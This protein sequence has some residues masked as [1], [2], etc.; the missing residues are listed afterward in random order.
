MKHSNLVV[1]AALMVQLTTLSLMAQQN[2]GSPQGKPLIAATDDS[3]SSIPLDPEVKTGKLENGFTYYIRKNTE[4]KGRVTLYLVNKTGSILETDAQQGLAHF[5]EHMCFNGTKH[6]PKNELINYLQKSG[7]RFG[8][9]LNAYTGFNE[10]VYQLPVATD[11]PVVLKNAFQILRDWAQD[12]TLDNAEIDKERGVVME[13][14]RQHLGGQQRTENKTIPVLFNHSRYADRLPIGKEDI[15]RHAPY[16]VFKKFYKDWYRPD[17]Q[18]LIVVGDINVKTIEKVIIDKFSDL[19]TPKN[20]PVREQYTIPLTGNTQFISIT[21]PEVPVTSITMHIKQ[22][23]PIIQSAASYKEVVLRLLLND[24]LSTR[25]FEQSQEEHLPFTELTGQLSPLEGNIEALSFT[26]IPKPGDVENAFKGIIVEMER[27]ARFGFTATEI[28]MAK[29]NVLNR[30]E[31]ALK[32]KDNTASAQFADEYVQHFTKGL[33][34]P[35]IEYDYKIT[36][37]MLAELSPSVVHAFLRSWQENRNKDIIITANQKD[38]AIIPSETQVSRWMQEAIAG[39]ITAYTDK[40]S[41]NSLMPLKPVPGKLKEQLTLKSIDV[42]EIILS[43]GARVLLKPTNFRKNEI[44]ITATSPGGLSVIDDAD[45]YAAT[46]IPDVI[47]SGGVGNFNTSSLQKILANKEVDIRPTISPLYEG[48]TGRASSSQ[49]ETALQLIN[50]YF[51]KPRRDQVAFNNLMSKITLELNS[52]SSIPEAVFQDTIDA[53]SMDYHVRSIRPTIAQLKAIKLDKV[54]DLYKERFADAGNFTF[55]L[56]GNFDEQVILPLLETY[57]GSLPSTNSHETWQDLKL[58]PAKGHISRKVFQGKEPKAQVYLSFSGEME[59]ATWKEESVHMIVLGQILQMKLIERLR[60]EESGIYNVRVAATPLRSPSPSFSIAITFSCD[61]KNVEL[62][63]LATH[64][65]MDKLK[66]E[67]PTEEDLEKV[68]AQAKMGIDQS[69]RT[70]LFWL[71]S[72]VKRTEDAVDL[73]TIPLLKNK[74]LNTGL[75][76][77]KKAA[78]K[79]IGGENYMRFVLLPVQ[80]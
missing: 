58:H 57:L 52:R 70:N 80:E 19:K 36:K 49:L 47:M 16:E 59:T 4:P 62:L 71:N 74:V 33:P 14:L 60:E 10:T 43:N 68:H 34:C 66:Q 72:L 40:T 15:I 56:V 54:L 48:L 61:P 3:R 26:A 67:G 69:L 20:A 51:T 64:S 78:N 76:D 46:L 28:E 11:D 38:E 1:S 45:Y 32:E 39:N 21:D 55:V 29:T 8:A 6:Y 73:E 17:L 18:A 53:V 22:V 65:E 41:G 2:P 7:V 31:S 63:I 13:E 12:A 9:D 77:V 44:L 50:L 79:F 42:T 23:Q 37:Q 75:N 24:M 35:G 30:M 5:M 25:L 27:I